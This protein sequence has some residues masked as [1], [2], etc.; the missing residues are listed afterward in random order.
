M[1]SRGIGEKTV[2]FMAAVKAHL[3]AQQTSTHAQLDTFPRQDSLPPPKCLP[4]SDR[5]EAAI[6]HSYLTRYKYVGYPY[7]ILA[8]FSKG[9]FIDNRFR[10]KYGDVCDHPFP[11][12]SPILESKALGRE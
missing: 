12:Q 5:G 10:V 7:R 3:F 9:A 11:N 6:L 4:G 8:G 2:Q 1:L